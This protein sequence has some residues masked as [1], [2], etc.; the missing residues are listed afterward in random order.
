MSWGDWMVVEFSIEEELQI[1][2]QARTVLHCHDAPEVA[3]LCSSLVKQN[4]YYSKLLRQA[5]GHIAQLE[6]EAFLAE[7]TR[8]QCVSDGSDR[9]HQDDIQDQNPFL[10]PL[11]TV[12]SFVVSCVFAAHRL[13]QRVKSAKTPKHHD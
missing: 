11:L 3:K 1:E 12:L 10:E 13:W 2:N 8:S 5:T 9:S 7:E 6:M 4:A